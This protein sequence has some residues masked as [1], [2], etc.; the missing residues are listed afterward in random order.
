MGVE[1]PGLLQGE[2][3]DLLLM[4]GRLL[5]SNLTGLSDKYT[6]LDCITLIIINYR[7]FFKIN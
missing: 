4:K 6:K 5:M 1:Y 2:L 3:L 7:L